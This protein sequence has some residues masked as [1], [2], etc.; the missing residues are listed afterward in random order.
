[1]A[2]RAGAVA[3]A[4]EA[5]GRRDVVV[6]AHVGAAAAVL[7][8]GV[9]LHLAAIARHVVAVEVREQ[10]GA[11]GARAVGAAGERVGH[12]AGIAARAAVVDVG[13]DVHLAAVDVGG[14]AVGE[15][16]VAHADGAGALGALR[17][18]V[19]AD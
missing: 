5:G 3:L 17:D 12:L 10:A 9:A 19:G 14:V 18:A 15:S 4:L 11:D 8:V 16:G 13:L 7:R 6:R 2:G 1:E